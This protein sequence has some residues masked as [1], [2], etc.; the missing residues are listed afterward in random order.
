MLKVTINRAKWLSGHLGKSLESFLRDKKGNM[1]CLGFACRAARIPARYILGSGYPSDVALDETPKALRDLFVEKEWV[2]T[3]SP[4]AR[5]LVEANDD[6]KIS[7]A[8]RER[9]IKSLGKQAGLQFVFTGRYRT[10]KQVY[11]EQ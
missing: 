11:G 10:A 2:R 8:V 3:D 4:V 9:R 7:P 1:C 6:L 5:S